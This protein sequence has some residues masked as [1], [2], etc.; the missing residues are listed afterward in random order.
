MKHSIRQAIDGILILDKP[1]GFSSNQALQKV[2]YLFQAKKAGHTGSLDPLATGMLPI[3][4]GQAT[5]FCQYLLDADKVY[6]V[7]LQLGEESST[8]DAEGERRKI[9]SPSGLAAVEIERVLDGFRG[10]IEQVPPMHSALKYKGVALYTLA[11]KGV[12]VERPARAVKIHQ[13][14]LDAI[15]LPYL[16][17][18]VRCSKG[19]YIRTLVQDIGRALGVGAYVVKLHRSAVAPYDQQ[20]LVSLEQLKCGLQEKTSLLPYLLPIDS[21]LSNLVALRLA[22]RQLVDLRHGRE[23]LI[24]QPI[25]GVVRLLS[26]EGVFVGAAHIDGCGKVAQ[27]RLLSL[28]SSD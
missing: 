13:L 10:D 2:K 7:L 1:L 17:L 6:E 14:S 16:R 9:K 20:P 27:R 3:C 22:P 23:V 4:F 18:T 11:R 15:D 19:T 24:Q 21:A 26:P 28:K 25:Q 12:E 5:K 8:G